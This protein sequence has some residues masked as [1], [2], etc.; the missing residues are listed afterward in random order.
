MGPVEAI[1]AIRAAGG[2]ASLAHFPE[3]PARLP[4]LRDLVAEGL[5][6]L[7]THHR[8]FDAETR[9]AMSAVATTLGLVETGGSDYHGDLGPYAETHALLVMP[10]DLVASLRVA[11]QDAPGAGSSLTKVGCRST[12]LPRRRLRAARL[13][14]STKTAKPIAA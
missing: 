6:G 13:R 14:T 7:E 5:D 10:D 9:S 11:P 1:R 12:A 3:A 4:L 2:L 8:S